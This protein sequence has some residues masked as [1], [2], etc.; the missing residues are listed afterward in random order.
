MSGVHLKKQPGG[1]GSHRTASS[2][3][4]MDKGQLRRSLLRHLRAQKEAV[5]R[6]KS[7]II[8]RKLSRLA[9]FRNAKVVLCYVSLPYEV[10]TWR[11]LS[12]M[13]EM[14]K[15]VIVPRVKRTTLGLSELKNPTTDLAPGAFG[16][17]EPTP[18]ARR[19]VR[20]DELELVLVPGLAFDRQGHRLGH[21]QGYFDRFLSC[22]PDTIPTIG[23]C[24]DFQLL[25]RLPTRPH[26]QRVH[27]VLSA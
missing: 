7:E 10:E 3:R 5:R 11:L 21:G 19:P 20:P 26:D 15:R 13:L 27:T 22:L 24:F 6:R 17:W 8:R 2:T 12:T 18:S 16:V 1:P 14:G 23:L 25:D 9:M 4:R